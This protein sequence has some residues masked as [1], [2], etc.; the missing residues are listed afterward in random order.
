M[1]RRGSACGWLSCSIWITDDGVRHRPR[2]PSGPRAAVRDGTSAGGRLG[3]PKLMLYHAIPEPV[4]CVRPLNMAPQRGLASC[5]TTNRAR[6]I[7]NSPLE[8]RRD[9]TQPVDVRCEVER[10][11]QSPLFGR[12]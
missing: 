4:R 8:R 10:R 6:V 2:H 9:G 11:L 7:R 12:R 3:H 1:G 5:S